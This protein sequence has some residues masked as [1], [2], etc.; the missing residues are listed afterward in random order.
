MEQNRI[1]GVV[2]FNHWGCRHG[3]GSL[4]VLHDALSRA[5]VPFLAID[6]DALDQPGAGN[7]VAHGQMESF[8][9]MF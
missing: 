6:G 9:E 8:L 5:G 4:P 7:S 1:D 3:M 2:H